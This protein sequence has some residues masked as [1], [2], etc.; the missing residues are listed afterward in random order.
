MANAVGCCCSVV[1]ARRR[2][3]RRKRPISRD[4]ES[5]R[6]ELKHKEGDFIGAITRIAAL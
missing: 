5:K 1:P 2:G 6:R 3:I 4:K